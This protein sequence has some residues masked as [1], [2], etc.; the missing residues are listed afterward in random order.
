MTQA[1]DIARVHAFSAADQKSAGGIAA[2][3]GS[4]AATPYPF[5]HGAG[6]HLAEPDFSRGLQLT[7]FPFEGFSEIAK[8]ETAYPGSG[9]RV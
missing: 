9:V 1:L 2:G 3:G 5:A 4:P 7:D 6:P 8:A